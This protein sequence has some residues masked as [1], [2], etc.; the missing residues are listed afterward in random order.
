MLDAAI[1]L[2]RK[3][4]SA[5]SR[6]VLV[7]LTGTVAAQAITILV[8]PVLTRLYTP[9]DFGVY[10]L[11]VSITA[12][13]GS[14]ICARY[15]LGIT[16]PAEDRQG[17]A[18]LGVCTLVSF[19]VAL[20]LVPLTFLFGGVLVQALN[21]P[22]L[23]PWLWLVPATMAVTGFATG[24]R[25][26]LLRRREFRTISTNNVLRSVLAAV[27][28]VVFGL[29]GWMQ[30]GLIGGLLLGLFVSALF[31]AWKIWRESGAD[32]RALRW[33]DLREQ[34][35][36][37]RRFPQYSLGSAVVESGAG[38]VP[39]FFFSSLFGASTLGWFSLAQRIAN[40]PLTLVA[41][42]VAD[43]FR[44]QASEIYARD[45]NCRTLFNR[46]FA[47]LFLLSLPAF[48]LAV[49]LS[50]WAFETIFGAAWRESGE[51]VRYLIPALALR[52][53]SNPLGSMFYIAQKQAA[54]LAIQ[55]TLVV[56]MVGVFVFAG[57]MGWSARHAVMAYSAIY[58]VKYLV[59]LF[60][61][62]RYAAGEA[63]A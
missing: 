27:F 17:L 26:W 56:V 29:L 55:S 47:K 22:R 4:L 28:N 40:L 11:F 43:V 14:V 61:A 24:A 5:F 2:R 18:L 3:Q 15:E 45:G 60:L 12:L 25:Y 32:I 20:L 23:Q 38:Q 36:A 31:L 39:V 41:Q 10:A 63:A 44:Q 53:I 58:S 49:W 19:G 8:S 13:L 52:F 9:A 46:T 37:Q 59:E 7:I 1:K 33:A 21:E 16:L 34:A 6:N 42:S 62:R 48:T 30:F 50:P 51:Y 35:V 54:D 57:R